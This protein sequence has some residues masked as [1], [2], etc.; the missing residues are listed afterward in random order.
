M[1]RRVMVIYNPPAGPAYTI[2]HT[3]SL[4]LST[5]EAIVNFT[6][7][8]F[9]IANSWTIALWFKDTDGDGLWA[10]TLDL[11]HMRP[12]GNSQNEIRLT[13]LGSAANDPVRM[14]IRNSSASVIKQ[15]D[16]NNMANGTGWMHLV[17]IWDGTILKGYRDGSEV[18]PTTK[19]TD[20]EGT[21]T[22]GARRIGVTN[23]ISGSANTPCIVH[24]VALWSTALSYAEEVASLY[25]GGSGY[26]YNVR[27]TN[28]ADLVQW[29][30]FGYAAGDN[31][32]NEVGSVDLGLNAT[33]I[34]DTDQV[35]D[36]PG[37]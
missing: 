11:F 17:F 36:Y 24:S 37:I 28:D 9:G 15:Y 7:N 19:T 35:A 10:G 30:L 13:I 27:N 23:S 20:T 26:N 29:T 5:T 16:W 3:K 25:N 2:S 33:N 31:F 22:D 18:A 32:H 4:D 1:G 8:T 6:N 14:L 21:M 34:D 12:S